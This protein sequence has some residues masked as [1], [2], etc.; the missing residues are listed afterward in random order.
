MLPLVPELLLVPA[1][2]P[3]P[4]EVLPL[5]EGRVEVEPPEEP[6]PERVL[7][8]DEPPEPVLGDEADVDPEGL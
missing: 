8:D 4:L 1:E 3:V 5:P 6:M 2:P 7:E